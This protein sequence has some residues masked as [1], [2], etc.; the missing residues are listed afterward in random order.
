MGA[1]LCAG[2]RGACEHLSFTSLR[3]VAEMSQFSSLAA[4]VVDAP[5]PAE[6]EQSPEKAKP[7]GV[8]PFCPC[9]LDRFEHRHIYSVFEVTWRIRVMLFLLKA[10]YTFFDCVQSPTCLLPSLHWAGHAVSF[11]RTAPRRWAEVRR[12]G[13][14]RVG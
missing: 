13:H 12:D 10:Q 11:V 2:T 14:V 4:A 9:S 7:A 1:A 5:E 3:P 8:R 6:P